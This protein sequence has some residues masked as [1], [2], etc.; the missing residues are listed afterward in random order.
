MKALRLFLMLLAV[1]SLSFVFTSCEE[2]AEN[3]V[4]GVGA[5]F[6]RLPDALATPVIV[7]I[8]LKPGTVSIPLAEI[9]RDAN[10]QNSLNQPV[11]VNLKIDQTLID[12]YNADKDDADKV[13]LLPS[14]LY[15]ADPL[16]VNMAA[17]DFSKF[18]NIKID[19]SKLDPAKKY[20][21]GLSISG[22][23]NAYKIRNGL[24]GALYTF[25]IKNEYDGKYQATGVFH[26]PT[27]GDRD[28]DEEKILVTVNSN[29]VITNLGDL[30]GAGYQMFLTV[31]AD[32]TVTIAPSG[33]TPNIDQSWGENYYDP[34]TKS[35]HLHYSYNTAAPRIIEE[36]IARK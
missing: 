9:L 15:Q 31:N 23:S 19:P 35:F 30:G 22:A 24:G 14:S 8:E 28:I 20:A 7:G 2:E 1:A 11:T 21:L 10:S 13:E 33:A 6:V 34:A 32:N 3:E 18:F 26:H 29:T 5:N 25:V 27:A 17:G 4:D 36:T 16:D 12:A